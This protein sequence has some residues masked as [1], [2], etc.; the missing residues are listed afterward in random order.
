MNLVNLR[1]DLFPALVGTVGWVLGRGGVI[2][3]GGSVKSSCF[4]RFKDL[5]KYLILRTEGK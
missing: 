2:S 1:E 3:G 5:I 4:D